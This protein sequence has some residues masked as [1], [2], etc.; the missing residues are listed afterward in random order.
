MSAMAI[1][2]EYLIKI[3]VIFNIFSDRFIKNQ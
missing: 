1:K 3:Y 2:L